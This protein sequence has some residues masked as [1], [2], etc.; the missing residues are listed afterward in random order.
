MLVLEDHLDLL[1]PLGLRV[2]QA[3]QEGWC[4]T[5]K[6][7]SKN[8]SV[9]NCRSTLR[10]CRRNKCVPQTPNRQLCSPHNLDQSLLKQRQ[11]Q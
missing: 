6:M 5:L 1:D 8:L 7:H 3:L 11:K 10:V 2:L 9:L 4:H